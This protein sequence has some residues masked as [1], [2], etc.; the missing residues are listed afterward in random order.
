MLIPGLP[1]EENLQQ[2]VQKPLT[3]QSRRDTL[4]IP[5]YQLSPFRLIELTLDVSESQPCTFNEHLR[6]KPIGQA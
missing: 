1:G 6:G 4:K 3:S 2:I 5:C